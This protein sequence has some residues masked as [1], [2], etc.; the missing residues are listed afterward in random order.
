[1]PKHASSTDTVDGPSLP[2]RRWPRRA[3]WLLAV[4]VALT[5]VLGTLT[6]L[7]AV[8]VRTDLVRGGEELQAGKRSL[9]AGDLGRATDSFHTAEATFAEAHAEAASGLARFVRLVP[10]LGRNLDV[11]AGT[12]IAGR[13]LALAGA[14]LAG[15]VEGLPDGI[16]SLAP[17]QGRPSDH[18]SAPWHTLP[19]GRQPRHRGRR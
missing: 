10:I 11:A 1:M 14:Q 8:G 9:A 17:T 4:A 5:L 16:G 2:R 12:A 6:L 18:S 13:E 3:G 15:A 19:P 7:A